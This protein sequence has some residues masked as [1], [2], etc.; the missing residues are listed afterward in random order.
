[1]VRQQIVPLLYKFLVG[2]RG[3]LFTGEEAYDGV[4]IINQ[5]IYFAGGNDGAA[6]NTLQIYDS[7]MD[8]WSVGTSLSTARYGH[9]AAILNNKY[10]VIGGDNGLET[11]IQWKFTIQLLIHGVGTPL[12]IA[13]QKAGAITVNGKI[14]IL[15]DMTLHPIPIRQS[16]MSMNMTRTRCM[17]SKRIYGHTSPWP[18]GRTLQ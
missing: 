4:E 12:P 7:E 5:K 11:L 1:M 2:R 13:Y 17:D 10:Y 16:I 6:S 9:A 8:S 3:K 14:L 15:A 18:C